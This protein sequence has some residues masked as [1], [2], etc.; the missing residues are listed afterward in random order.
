M[1][2]TI[3]VILA[4]FTVGAC[5]TLPGTVA[6]SPGVVS[7]ADPRAAEAGAAMLRQGG[8]ASDAVFAT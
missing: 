2:K 4:S 6:S 3:L 5:T 7:A 8:S 1:R